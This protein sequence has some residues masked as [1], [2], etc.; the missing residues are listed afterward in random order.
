MTKRR[1]K[2]NPHKS[3]LGWLVPLVGGP[4]DGLEVRTGFFVPPTETKR[5]GKTEPKSGYTLP[6]D[7]Q[8]PF[9]DGSVYVLV[10]AEEPESMIY[11][12]RAA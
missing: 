7:E 4:H 5:Q 11:E 6:F 12:W 3:S 8:M 9:P 10:G 1:R 2:K